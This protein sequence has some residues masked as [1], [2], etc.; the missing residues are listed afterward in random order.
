MCRVAAA[1]PVMPPAAVQGQASTNLQRSFQ[2]RAQAPPAG[3]VGSTSQKVHSLLASAELLC[4][5]YKLS[6]HDTYSVQSHGLYVID[7]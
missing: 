7:V 6:R 1:P 2:E 4:M 3:S 5:H